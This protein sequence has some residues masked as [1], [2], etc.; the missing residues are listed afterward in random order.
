MAHMSGTR[1]FPDMGFVQNTANNINFCYRTNS[2]EINDRIFQHIQKTL[3]FGPFSQFLGK[4]FFF[5]KIRLSH[6]ISYGFLASC[7]NLEKTN[8]TIPRKRPD[9]RKGGQ[10]LFYRTLPATAASPTSGGEH[11][12]STLRVYIK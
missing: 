1:T 8:D 10:A 6:T 11:L 5:W 3:F 12:L 2:V 4:I 9:R 7:Q